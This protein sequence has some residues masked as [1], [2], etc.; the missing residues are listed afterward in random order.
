MSIWS[1]LFGAKEPIDATAAFMN[2]LDD[3]ISDA[4]EDGVDDVTI[5]CIL[6]NATG[7]KRW[8]E[9]DLMIS[10]KPLGYDYS[11]AR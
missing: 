1:R 11:I 7:A 4:V 9:S 10:E 3:V 6:K 5:D 2:E 8:R